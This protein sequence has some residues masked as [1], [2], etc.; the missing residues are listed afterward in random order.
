[1]QQ[2][3]LEIVYIMGWGLIALPLH[4]APHFLIDRIQIWTVRRP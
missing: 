4:H 2:M 3:L 1:M